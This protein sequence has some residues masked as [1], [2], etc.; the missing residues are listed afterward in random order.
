M[1]NHESGHS[2]PS[3]LA[4]KDDEILW[5]IPLSSKIDKYKSIIEKKIKKYGSCK[6]IL[7]KK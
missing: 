2:R 4:I 5:F 7:I 6:T 1:I 3:Y